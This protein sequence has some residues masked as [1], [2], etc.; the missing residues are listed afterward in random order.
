[1]A[2]RIVI[3]GGGIVGSCTALFL[4]PH[5]EVLVL[6]KDPTYR[7]AST[8]L[9]AASFRQQFSLAVNLHM[10]RFGAEF[11]EQRAERVGLIRR[12]YLILATPAGEAQLKANRQMQLAEGAKVALFEGPAAIADRFPWLHTEDLACATL[13][14]ENEGWFDAYSLLRAVREEAIA[15]GA[16]YIADEATGIDLAGDTVTAVHT[17]KHDRIAAGHV[18]IAAGRHAGHVGAMAGIPL[19]IEPRKRTVFVLRAPLDNAGMP[20]VFDTTGAW[21]R[22]EGD[23]FIGG[24][25]PAPDNDPNPGEDFDPDLDLLEDQVWPALAHRIPVLERLRMVRAWA[26]HYDMCLFDHNAVIGHHPDIAN[27]IVAAGFSGHGVQHGPAAGRAV[28]ELIR[29]GAYRTLDL[30]PLGYERIRDNRPMPELVV[31]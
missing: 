27:L 3:I 18:V 31:Y 13:G 16:R 2:S 9:S 17:A 4:V 30:T 28:S 8:T 19:P 21:L 26:G 7:F 20:L 10:S 23:G 6:E 24:I 12:A 1:M 25:S 29:F 15:A 14:L 22:P 5:A 11:L